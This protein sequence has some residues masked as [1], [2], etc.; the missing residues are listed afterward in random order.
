MSPHT[1][2]AALV[3][4]LLLSA[5]GAPDNTPPQ[6]GNADK[7]AVVITGWGEPRGWD[8]DFRLAI[9]GDARI[10][11][12]TLY[13]GQACTE[14]HAGRWPFASQIGLLPHAVA[15][16]LPFLGAAWD[17]MGIYRLSEN[18]SEFESIIDSSVR[19]PV[20]EV[21]DVEGMITPMSASGLFPARSLGGVDPR[22]GTD[23]L[24]GI[25]QLGA[26]SRERGNNPLAM[27]NGLSD[28]VELGVAGSMMD[29][30][31]MYEDQTPRAN[32][33][34]ERMTAVTI[35]T[36]QALFGERITAR[37][38]AYAATP[39]IHPN[40]Q[41]VALD[42]VEQGYTRLVLTRET[43]DNSQYANTFMT[44][45]WIDKALCLAGYRDDVHIKQ[46]RQVGRTPEY[47][48]ALLE[49]LRPHLERREKGSEVAIIYTTY[50]MPF[51]GG[52]DSGPFA[53]V[54][55]LAKEEY[56]ENA[57]LNYQSFKRYA[58]AEFGSDFDLRFTRGEK[59]NHKRT[60]AYFAYAMFPSRFYGAA[61]DPLRFSTLRETI[62]QAKGDGRREI[63]V[64]LSHWNYN[65]TDNML[66]I[67]KLNRI[68][69][70]S[71]E[72][73]RQQKYWIDWCELPGSPEPVD[74]D[75]PGSI[76]LS[77]SEVFDRQ[78]E[79]FGIG[80]AQRIRGTVERFGV[81]PDGVEA[82]TSAP[83]TALEGG[84]LRIEAGPL[85]G[86]ALA[87]PADPEPGLPES[88]TWDD[89]QVFVS[90][91]RPFIGAWFDFEAYAAVSDRQPAGVVGP[92]VLLGPYRT[93]VNKP[94]RVTL[95]WR[96]DVDPGSLRPV[97][98]NEVTGGWDPVFP[99]AGG[100]E[101]TLDTAARTLSFDTQ[102]LGIFALVSD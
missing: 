20:S 13:P 8:F 56:H 27:P 37:F 71:R 21:Q 11:E 14:M 78:A 75:S 81:M 90:P 28:V 17:S 41:Q 82:V 92:T 70:N 83:V 79:A 91:S 77:F 76:R 4:G 6:N 102:V 26:P 95:P 23:Y 63:V 7:V 12:A 53:T 99:V 3:V 64:L 9:S 58:R 46:T 52:S 100:S 61:D 66:A 19:I 80:Y 51:P 93:I 89:Y 50:G 72:D 47:N 16:K 87:V 65:N 96:G 98:Y 36:L 40:Q 5:C 15:Y 84:E 67:R 33:V 59:T 62:T 88:N 42:F 32:E 69:Y 55:P 68:P 30:G 73:V 38:G 25:Y 94:A 44:R 60:N 2:F 86:V 74:C 22:D 57:Y 24:A 39:G 97:I 45:G 49:V 35:D 85:A 1:L 18:G 48:T 43:T 29:M 34:D 101:A 54:H 31:F 10:G